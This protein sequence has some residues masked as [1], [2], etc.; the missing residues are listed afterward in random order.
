MSALLEY[1]TGLQTEAFY[2]S[3]ANAAK[4]GN[5][6]RQLALLAMRAARAALVE[7]A[8][9]NAGDPEA[10]GELFGL[11]EWEAAGPVH[12]SFSMA[13][14]VPA[15]MMMEHLGHSAA[16]AESD[17]EA[18][19]FLAPLLPMA[20]KALPMVTKVAA[21]ALPKIFSRVSKVAPKLIRGVQGAAKTLRTNPVTRDLVRALPNVVRKT[22]A[23]LAQ[24]VANGQNV[25][26]QSAVRTLAKNTAALLGDPSTVVQTIRTAR[27][28]DQRVHRA[29]AAPSLP[30]QPCC[31]CQ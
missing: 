15:R 6:H 2:E 19:A 25:T 27:N 7:G 5:K 12:A 4:S 11:N 24:Q 9:D 22:T 26:G 1:E 16:E 17:G 30:S 21:K 10:E 8:K 13:E 20:L 28:A 31:H 14:A 3:V 18:F 23:D 29:L